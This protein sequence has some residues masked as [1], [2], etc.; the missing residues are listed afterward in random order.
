MNKSQIDALLNNKEQF[1]KLAKQGYEEVDKNKNGSLD[2]NEIK[3]ILVNFA[4]RSGLMP[5][6]TRKS[7]KYISSLIWIRTEKSTS[8]SLK[9]SL[10]SFWGCDEYWSSITIKK[11]FLKIIINKHVLLFTYCKQERKSYL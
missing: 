1:E 8:L 5:Q 6:L 7:N 11:S 2:F 4:Q 3:S 9:V 10:G